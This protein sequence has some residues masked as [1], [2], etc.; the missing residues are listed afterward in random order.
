M[1]DDDD[2]LS[3]EETE[4]NDDGENTFAEATL[5]EEEDEH[6]SSPLQNLLFLLPL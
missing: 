5:R 4:E 2:D 1:T 3:I 6:P